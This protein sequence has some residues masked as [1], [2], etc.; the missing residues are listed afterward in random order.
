MFLDENQPTNMA[1]SKK[2][3]TEIIFYTTQTHICV[4]IIITI[5]ND[6]TPRYTLD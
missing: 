1:H 4:I 2:V 6:L 3:S 5:I